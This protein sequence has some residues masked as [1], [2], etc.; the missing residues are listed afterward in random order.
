MAS[1]WRRFVQFLR[2]LRII[3]LRTEDW[4][5]STW[6]WGVLTEDSFRREGVKLSSALTPPSPVLSLYFTSCASMETKKTTE[7]T[8]FF[9]RNAKNSCFAPKNRFLAYYRKCRK[10]LNIRTL[11]T[12]C[13][14]NLLAR[15]SRKLCN[16][17]LSSVHTWYL[18]FFYTHTYWGLK[19]LHSKARKFTTKKTP[20]QNSVNCATQIALRK[21]PSQRTNL[22]IYKHLHKG[23]TITHSV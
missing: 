3:G 14:Y 4:R 10:N 21:L 17:G 6:D 11:G 5:L 18:S 23:C 2:I 7:N 12:K 16:S 15:T 19:I 20:R 13:W 9:C 8:A 22:H 1:G